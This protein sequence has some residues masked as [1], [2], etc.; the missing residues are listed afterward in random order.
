MT[1][2]TDIV[3]IRTR[4]NAAYGAGNFGL[5]VVLFM[6]STYLL[7]YYS[8]FIGLSPALMGLAIVI[9]K[10]WDAVCDPLLGYISDRTRSRW[11]RR[12]VYLLFA[13]V[14]LAIAFYFMWAPPSF[15]TEDPGAGLFVYITCVWV[16]LMTLYAAVAVPYY[17]LGA[18]IS[19]DEHERSQA[20]AWSNMGNRLGQLLAIAAAN[21][22]LEFGDTLVQALHN[23]LGLFSDATTQSLV[24][25]F[26]VPANGLQVVVAFFSILLLASILWSFFGTRERVIYRPEEK[27]EGGLIGGVKAF[28]AETVGNFKSKAFRVLII[29]Q[30]IG[31]INAGMMFS[32]FPYAL[33]Y[34]FGAED[35]LA[36]FMAVAIICGILFAFAWVKVAKK[37]G[38][39]WCF[40]AAQL[41]YAI[42]MLAMMAVP[43]GAPLFFLPCCVLLSVGI[44][45]YVMVWS[46]IADIADYEELRTGRRREGSL[47]GIYNLSSK[48]ANAIGV[49]VTGFVIAWLGFTKGA[50]ITS[51]MTFQLR[52]F[53]TV[54]IALLNIVG[55]LIF[56]RYPYD[57]EE[58]KRIQVELKDRNRDAAG[59]DA[60][61]APV[62]TEA[63]A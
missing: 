52:L 48:T 33:K 57:R 19:T 50:T 15:L 59:A 8:D 14:P 10:V 20:F 60:A 7:Y 17:A 26:S 58:H 12:R 6:A 1:L 53:F 62:A 41:M 32:T 21:A 28:F 35:Y 40:L 27:A 24:D 30:L 55:F 38:K 18:E 25:Y 44:G 45:G 63:P 16:A 37:K 13:S 23:K 22:A 43:Q 49:G 47:Y 54:G 11:G 51:D 4:E 34:V 29:S 61:P 2:G 46:L 36:P 42:A 56:L 39:K 5:G 9:G 3:K 31:D